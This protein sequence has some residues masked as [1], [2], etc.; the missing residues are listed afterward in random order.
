MTCCRNATSC[1]PTR[2]RLP[3]F[4]YP[5]PSSRRSSSKRDPMAAPPP[6]VFFSTVAGINTRLKAREFSAEE[7]ARAISERL[8]RLGPRFNALALSLHQEALRA[9]KEVDM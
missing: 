4:P 9:A 2:R 1:A 5:W 6:D 8:Q 3:M 7:L